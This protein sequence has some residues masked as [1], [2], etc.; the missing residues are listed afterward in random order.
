MSDTKLLAKGCLF[1]MGTSIFLLDIYL[2]AK[3]KREKGWT[4]EC[5]IPFQNFDLINFEYLLSFSILIISCLPIK[6]KEIQ[7]IIYVLG[8]AFFIFQIIL[9]VELKNVW[10]EVN[11][12]GDCDVSLGLTAFHILFGLICFGSFYFIQTVYL[13]EIKL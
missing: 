9:G 12:Q 7:M 13:I 3:E 5:S 6:T 2:F 1:L 10:S 8:Q 11:A 4:N